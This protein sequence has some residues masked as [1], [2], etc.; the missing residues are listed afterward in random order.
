M[1]EFD[2][3]EELGPPEIRPVPERHSPARTALIAAGVVLAGVILAAGAFAASRM[4]GGVPG[5]TAPGPVATSSPNVTESFT[6]TASGSAASSTVVTM[7]APGATSTVPVG[8]VHFTRGSRVAYR[9]DGFL[10]VAEESGSDP[11]KVVASQ[12]GAFSLSPDGETIAF[13]DGTTKTLALADAESGRVTT[14]GPADVRAP[15]W[16]PSSKWLAFTNGTE[17]RRVSADGSGMRYL[18]RG[19]HPA[20][21]PDD[22]SYAYAATDSVTAVDKDGTSRSLP[23]K[24]R[25]DDLALGASRIYYALGGAS[26]S[27]VSLHSMALAG[28][29]DRQLVGAPDD[30]AAGRYDELQLSPDGTWLA[31]AS[32]GDDLHSRLRAMHVDGAADTSLSLRHDDYVLR[33]SADGSKVLFIDGNVL[34][35]DSPQLQSVRPDGSQRVTLIKGAGM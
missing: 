6:V 16:S 19:A 5:V 29:G 33:W 31:Y 13:V 14:V 20:I 10:W 3:W 8:P 26:R 4:G 23:V 32:A 30:K 25:V 1:G 28:T 24:G 22:V 27:A 17:V 35:G 7:T 9:Q 15:V 34:Q 21:G 12:S 18:G 2:E 11:R